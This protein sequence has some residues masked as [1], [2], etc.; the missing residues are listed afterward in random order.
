MEQCLSLLKTQASVIFFKLDLSPSNVQSSKTN[1]TKSDNN[2]GDGVK[3]NDIC[4][5]YL[6]KNR[7]KETFKKKQ[8]NK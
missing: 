1:R 2:K 7:K 4:D 8:T 3:T 5:G 6:Y